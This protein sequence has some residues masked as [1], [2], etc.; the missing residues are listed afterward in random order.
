[1]LQNVEW[2]NQN[3]G[4]AYPFNEDMQRL[5]TNAAGDT[6]AELQLPNAVVVDF[7]FTLPGT[8]GTR[9]Y[10]SQL[11]YVGNL[12]T[13]VFNETSGDTQIA[14][15][16]VN[17][18]T[19]APNTA[20]ALQGSGV[21]SD[22]LG[23]LVVGDLGQFLTN[24]PEGLYNFT[25]DQTLLEARTVRPALRGVRYLRTSNNGALSAPLQGNIKLLA[26]ANIQLTY[27]AL[28]NGIWIS[29]VPNAGYQS[30]CNCDA[31]SQQNIV[32]TINGIPVEDVTIV[33]DDSCV[34]VVTAGNTITISDTCSKPCCGCPELDFLTN[35]INVLTAS[36]TTLEGYAQ[37]LDTRITQFITNFGLTV[38]TGGCSS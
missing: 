36:V 26:G 17:L 22:G 19:H 38:G 20:Y 14:T 11:A 32:R 35:T 24:Y 3:A 4:R 2:L 5:P 31:Q 6:L 34:S 27:D 12:M 21:W 23:W 7:L 16:T 9:A 18:N 30:A 37:Q 28:N 15:V 8:P 25:S 33:G 13:F 10:L 1:M 29:A